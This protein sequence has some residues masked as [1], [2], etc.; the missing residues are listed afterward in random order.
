MNKNLWTVD[1]DLRLLESH[2]YILR[3]LEAQGPGAQLTADTHEV[4]VPNFM[5]N[6]KT[7]DI[8]I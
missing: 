6:I 5:E 1:T 7:S 4:T 2:Y 3:I 8:I